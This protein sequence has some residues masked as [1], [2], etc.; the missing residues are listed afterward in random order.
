MKW[1]AKKYAVFRGRRPGVYD[2]PEAAREQVLGFSN[3]RIQYFSTLAQA[4]AALLLDG[5]LNPEFLKGLP[6]GGVR[7]FLPAGKGIAASIAGGKAHRTKVMI[8]INLPPDVEALAPDGVKLW[9]N[10]RQSK[11]ALKLCTFEV[12]EETK[13]AKREAKKE[14]KRAKVHD[15]GVAAIHAAKAR[16]S[17]TRPSVSPGSPPVASYTSPAAAGGGGSG[18]APHTTRGGPRLANSSRPVPV[19]RG[20]Q[21]LPAAAASPNTSS[22]PL[23]NCEL[24]SSSSFSRGASVA[25]NVYD[26]ERRLKLKRGR[27]E[28][29]DD[30]SDG[31]DSGDDNDD[32][33]GDDENHVGEGKGDDGEGVCDD[34][35]GAGGVEERYRYESG[36]SGWGGDSA[37]PNSEG[38]SQYAP[39]RLP[40]APAHVAPTG[41]NIF[42]D[43]SAALAP[44]QGR[45]VTP[46]PY[47]PSYRSAPTG[48]NG[49]G[50]SSS[51][52]IGDGSFRHPPMHHTGSSGGIGDGSFRHPFIIEAP[53]MG[54]AA[55]SSSAAILA[56][57]GGS[58]RQAPLPRA[59]P[60]GAVVHQLQSRVD[61]QQQQL[62]HSRWGPGP[63][64][65]RRAD[66][67]RG[68]GTTGSSSS[69]R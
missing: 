24:L 51:G 40:H 30:D 55:P 28:E 26:A 11:T 63:N 60:A 44:Y 43:R 21:R 38:A 66:A 67:G 46:A 54:Y 59:P 34:G 6:Q 13:A 39:A 23:L 32:D 14:A 49:I 41:P 2:T 22:V 8:E 33:D 29:D 69:R 5:H 62:Q 53:P 18:P 9:S 27:D 36:G 1:H 19:Q 10:S 4:H 56:M 45:Y 3:A 68:P 47:Q 50:A 7:N 61:Q 16:L 12:R 42:Y 52:S 64:K 15:E 31:D 17:W 57:K 65:G 20:A 37:T 25:T 35:E 48:N 58:G